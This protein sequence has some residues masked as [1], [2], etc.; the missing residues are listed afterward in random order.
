[1]NIS[2]NMQGLI[3]AAKFDVEDQDTWKDALKGSIA[4]A[5]AGAVGGGALG[6]G[7]SDENKLKNTLMGTL[8]GGLGFGGANALILKHN[9]DS[10]SDIEKFFDYIAKEVKKQEG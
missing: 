4:P 3:K 1:M 5:I 10:R 2:V 8:M 7:L 9:L 6:F